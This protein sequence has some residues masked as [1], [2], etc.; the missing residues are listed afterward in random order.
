MSKQTSSGVKKAEKLTNTTKSAKSSGA[1]T[2]KSDKDV[3]KVVK[4]EDAAPKKAVKKSAP[5]KKNAVKS[6]KV[7]KARKAKNITKEKAAKLKAR[8]EKKLHLAQVRAEKKQ[9]RLEK[10]LEAKQKRLDRIAAMKEKREERKAARQQRRDVLKHETKEK[11]IERKRAERDAKIEARIQRHKAAVAEK[12]AK[13]EH[14]LKV[15]A[16]KRAEKNDKRHAPGFGGWLAAVIALGVTTLALGTMMTFGWI[17][18]NGM[19]ADMAQTHTQSLYELNSVVDNLDTNLAKARVSSSK[20]EQVKILSQIAIESE[21]AETILERFPVEMQLTQSMTDFVNKMGDSAKGMLY[22]VARGEK[23]T[24]SQIATIDHMYST[25]MQLKQTINEL[26]ANMSEKDMIAAMRGKNG[27]MYTT[28]DT[29]QNNAVETP[30]E[31]F[32]G[33]FAENIE[34]SSAKTLEGREEISAARAEELAKQYFKDYKVSAA[35]CT[36]EVLADKIACYNV[37]LTTPDGDMGAQISKMGGLVVEFN[38]YKDCSAKNFSVDRCITIAEDF[39]ASLGIDNMKAV[40]TSENETT[41][42]LNF[43]YVQ[44]GVVIYPDMI[45]V[46]V[47]E[48]RGIV[49]GMEGLAYVLNHTE[50]ELAKAAISAD[51][52]QSGISGGFEVETSRLCLIP[53]DGSEVLAHE[54]YGTYDGS[55]YYIYLDAQTGEEVELFTVIGTKQ[56]RALM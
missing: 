29:I 14:R 52:A 5:A 27:L 37:T 19:Q 1:K 49:T 48:E 41:C 15:R 13:R 12:Q 30:K 39:L 3:E 43:A 11:R 34:K 9:K 7:K 44:N 6:E 46:K 51:E 42:N 4:S 10:K 22:A 32:D 45:K 21:I 53:V 54:F 35:T 50:R 8:E 23:L 38:S 36:G 47:C 24:D 2:N 20:N 56:G 16:Q 31:I 18:M 33:P 40:W 26:V 25:N 55:A 17:T 28:F